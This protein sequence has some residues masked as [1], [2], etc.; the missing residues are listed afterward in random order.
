M[1]K[2]CAKELLHG[3]HAATVVPL[4]TDF[5]IHVSE[6]EHYLHWVCSH[7]GIRGLLV[8]GHA[9]ENFLLSRAEK[10]LVLEVARGVTSPDVILVAG[11]NSENSSEA[12]EQARDA[13]RLGANAILV[14]PPNS[15]A[16]SQDHAVVEHHHKC[17]EGSCQLPVLLYQA[18]VTA[19][20]MSY[21]KSLLHKLIE[22][23][24]VIGIKEGSWEL[25][26]YEETLRLVRLA[27]PD[28]AVLGSGDEHLL[29]TYLIG[30]EGSQVSLAAIVPELVV[31]LFNAA[32][33][34]DWVNAKRLHDRLYGLAVAIYRNAPSS[35]ATARMKTCLKLLGK[36]GS[37]AVKP[38][39]LSTSKQEAIDLENV[40]SAALY[41][42]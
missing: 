19:G 36:I 39:Q 1:S 28:I 2:T 5:S 41:N 37:D 40:L 6:L 12:A 33:E 9:G 11:I 18:P 29:A 23:P 21:E 38:P 4:A 24:R 35:R 42:R 3:I 32:N 31:N 27:R 30:T 22:S 25:S 34:N 7:S 13:E 26:A 17:I 15:W 10:A 14:F 20:C 16:L 8:N